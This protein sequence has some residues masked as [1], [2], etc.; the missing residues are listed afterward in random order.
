[1]HGAEVGGGGGGG[2]KFEVDG[3]SS[4]S[5]CG[6]VLGLLS[7]PESGL[8]QEILAP[9]HANGDRDCRITAELPS[10][11]IALANSHR[12]TC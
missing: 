1:M 7:C 10:A 11:Y 6:Y 8:E 3:E 4:D 2:C 5:Q 9:K 12:L